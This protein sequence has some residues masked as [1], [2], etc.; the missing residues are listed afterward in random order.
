VWTTN[1]RN[2]ADTSVQNTHMMINT[3]ILIEKIYS[4]L[5]NRFV[6]AGTVLYCLSKFCMSGKNKVCTNTATNDLNN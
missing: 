1:V 5:L 4:A 3:S 2:A 6:K